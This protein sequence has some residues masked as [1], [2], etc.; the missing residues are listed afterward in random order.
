[1]TSSGHDIDLHP[2]RSE[3]DKARGIL[4]AAI[5]DCMDKGITQFRVVHGKGKGHFRKLVHSHL[6]RHADVAGYVLCDPSHGGS[7]A[8]WVYLEGDPEVDSL[9]NIN[10]DE[11]GDDEII[12]EENAIQP[13]RPV[14]R[15]L[16][17]LVFLL[18]VFIAFPQWYVR[19]IMMLF[20]F[21]ME[22]RMATRDH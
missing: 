21:W 4:N 5:A 10:E 17:Y 20:I 8:S 19:G 2:Y 3:P 22:I 1:M 12:D 6:D 16:I 7:G 14:W 15:W 9:E 13:A 18:F 11:N